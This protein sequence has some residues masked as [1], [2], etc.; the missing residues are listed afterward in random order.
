L[1]LLLKLLRI[2]PLPW[3]GYEVSTSLFLIGL[4]L[5]Y[6]SAYS[7]LIRLLRS[8][9][10]VDFKVVFS[11]VLSGLIVVFG[12]LTVGIFREITEVWWSTVI[13]A[14]F[15]LVGPVFIEALRRLEV[16]IPT[17]EE[18]PKDRMISHAVPIV[19]AHPNDLVQLGEGDFLEGGFGG[20]QAGKRRQT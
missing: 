19:V 6:C 5:G 7:A 8:E 11:S 2:R 17:G 12:L 9:R 14:V 15:A 18:K 13:L 4:F 1:A 16:Q 10:S 20:L 3:V